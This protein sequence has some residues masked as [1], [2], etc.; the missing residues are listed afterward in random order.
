M[1]GRIARQ[2]N[3]PPRAFIAIVFPTYGYVDGHESQTRAEAPAASHDRDIRMPRPSGRTLP[4]SRTPWPSHTW[5][6]RVGTETTPSHSF[7]VQL[8]GV[9]T[10]QH[11]CYAL[12]QVGL[13]AGQTVAEHRRIFHPSGR[14]TRDVRAC[15]PRWCSLYKP[16]M[17]LTPSLTFFSYSALWS[18]HMTA[19]STLAGLSPLGS[20]SMLITE[21]SIFSTD[22][23]GLQRSEACS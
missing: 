19:A 3:T 18:R 17:R 21:I 15:H 16:S 10:I 1:G 11:H 12:N 8:T 23:M 14:A 20:A 6:G 22:W 7:S 4:T 5:A 13:P 9:K 2:R